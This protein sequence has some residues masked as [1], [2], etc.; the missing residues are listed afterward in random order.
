MNASAAGGAAASISVPV[1]WDFLGYHV[2]A[3]PLIVCV[4]ATLL[5]RLIVSL[6][7]KGGHRWLLDFAVTLLSVLVAALWVQA[8]DLALLQA[9]VT[10]ISSGALGISIISIAKSQA[11][12]ALR[13]AFGTF[14]RGVVPPEPYQ[15][16]RRSCLAILM[17]TCSTS[18]TEDLPAPTRAM[19]DAGA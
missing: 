7:T 12:I 4:C 1:V 2:Q 15:S 19:V 6:N 14:L 17:Q 5:T 10:G 9:G 13:A 3:G 8:H 18:S 16:R 11:S